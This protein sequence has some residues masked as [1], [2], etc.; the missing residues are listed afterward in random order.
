M[1]QPKG[2]EEIPLPLSAA[3]AR[4]RRVREKLI[5]RGV[6]RVQSDNRRLNRLCNDTIREIE[7]KQVRSLYEIDKTKRQ[8]REELQN[9]GMDVSATPPKRLN[10]EVP[11]DESPIQHVQDYNNNHAE[12]A[13]RKMSNIFEEEEEEEEDDEE[14]AWEASS[15][16]SCSEL[17]FGDE[18]IND[19]YIA[20]KCAQAKSSQNKTSHGMSEV[21]SDSRKVSNPSRVM[22]MMSGVSE[23]RDVNESDSPRKSNLLKRVV[24][25]FSLAGSTSAAKRPGITSRLSTIYQNAMEEAMDL[26]P[27]TTPWSRLGQHLRAANA[28]QNQKRH[29]FA[30]AATPLVSSLPPGHGWPNPG[31]PQLQ[32]PQLHRNN[33]WAGNSTSDFTNVQHSPTPGTPPI[34]RS[35]R[36]K[37]AH[38][39]P[40]LTTDQKEYQKFLENVRNN[41]SRRQ[42]RLEHSTSMYMIR[43]DQTMEN[44]RLAEQVD[45]FLNQHHR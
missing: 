9:N 43:Y 18:D 36:L 2:G 25:S 22:S 38:P 11:G 14:D 10:P 41:V 5:N 26:P 23:S 31:S 44:E 19:M 1:A 13:Q 20:A 12:R 45:A 17:D 16:S 32:R 3:R 29:G 27:P 21:D 33:T 7:K 42:P 39:F 4:S 15:T 28:I 35:S 6:E 24:S 40:S 8:L 34:G 30:P 37:H